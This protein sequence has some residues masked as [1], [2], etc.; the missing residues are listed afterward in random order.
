MAS[1]FRSL[2]VLYHRACINIPLPSSQPKWPLNPD[3]LTLWESNVAVENHVK[4]TVFS[5]FF[6][7]LN[8]PLVRADRM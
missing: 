1:H 6:P 3:Q 4:A 5:I 8:H 7:A 2:E